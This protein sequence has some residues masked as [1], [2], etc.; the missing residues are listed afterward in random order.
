MQSG[1]VYTIR[2]HIRFLKYTEKK[3]E[4]LIHICFRWNYEFVDYL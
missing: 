1:Y 2:M 4:G 3:A